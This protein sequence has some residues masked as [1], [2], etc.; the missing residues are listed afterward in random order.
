[1]LDLE[2]LVLLHSQTPGF[3]LAARKRNSMLSLNLCGPQIISHALLGT[4]GGSTLA[5]AFLWKTHFVTIR[6]LALPGEAIQ[7]TFFLMA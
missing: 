4:M 2:R 7:Q 1:M 5:T 6:F 3:A